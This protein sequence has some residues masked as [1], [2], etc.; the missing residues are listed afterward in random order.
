M[1]QPS[2]LLAGLASAAL[3]LA[4]AEIR[5]WTVPWPNTRPRDPYVDAQG[6]VWFAGQRGDYVAV[7]DPRTGQFRR[8][9]LPTG[10]APHNVVVDADGIVWYTGNTQ[11]Y[12]G[13]L[14]PATGQVTRYPLPDSTLRDP[15]TLAF[16]P[17]GDLWFTVQAG[18]AVG[19]LDRRTGQI[20]ILRIPIPN[21][22]PY[23]IVV[24]R[25]GRPWFNLFGTHLIGTIDPQTWQLRTYPLGDTLVRN[26]RIGLS[27]DG[28]VWF[29]DYARGR[30]GRLDPA[31][32]QV[33]LWTTP[34]GERSR[35]Y[36][37]AVDDRDRVWFVETGSRPNRLVGFDPRT[38][39]FVDI[40]E[41]PSG[42]LVVRHMIYHAP[43]R[44]L[45]FGTD[46][47][48]I[49]QARLP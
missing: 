2:F 21:A 39:Q 38:E 14:D 3:A 12:I 6:R 26:R 4:A 23:G 7:L 45:W 28:A 16:D 49:G 19:K 40:T 47:N 9:D 32:G 15:H 41:V 30:L 25:Q 42:G 20:R 48:T 18:N 11:A 29:V 44:S 1:P 37:M 8:Y 10:A 17:Q 24:D 31:T 34:G 22:R 27:S 35:P 46:A 13:R 5:E 33:R 36:A 43:T